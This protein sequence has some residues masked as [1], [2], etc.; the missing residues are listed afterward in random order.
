M[1][2]VSDDLIGIIVYLIR[3]MAEQPMDHLRLVRRKT[4][5]IVEETGNIVSMHAPEIRHGKPAVFPWQVRVVIHAFLNSQEVVAIG[6]IVETG[7]SF[8]TPATLELDPASYTVQCTYGETTLTK[9]VDILENETVRVDFQFEAPPTPPVNMMV[10][11]AGAAA[12]TVL[13][14]ALLMSRRA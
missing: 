7:Q 1:L 14:A 2:L 6:K 12:A 4:P 9:S 8:T 13:A 5:H 11:G 10:V 3:Q